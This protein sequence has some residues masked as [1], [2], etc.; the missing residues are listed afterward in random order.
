[1]TG[2]AP[3]ASTS[4]GGGVRANLGSRFRL[5]A[6]LAFPLER[7]GLQTKRGDPRLLVTLTSR[8][9]PWR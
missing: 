7:A 1:M 6:A 8:L 5:D 2:A 4:A 9:I 3:S